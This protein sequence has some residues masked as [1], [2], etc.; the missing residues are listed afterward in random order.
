MREVVSYTHEHVHLFTHMHTH[1]QIQGTDTQLHTHSMY[2][3][4]SF[5]TCISTATFVFTCMDNWSLVKAPFCDGISYY[6]H[7]SHV[8]TYIRFHCTHAS[9][10]LLLFACVWITAVW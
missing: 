2:V 10:L 9:P 3:H 5:D 7:R 1:T 6:T 8:R 4:L